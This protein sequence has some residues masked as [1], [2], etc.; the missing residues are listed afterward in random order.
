MAGRIVICPKCN[1]TIEDKLRI[2]KLKLL[3][4]EGRDEEEFFGVLLEKLGIRDVQ[5]AGVG[6]KTKIRPNLKT[7]KITDPFFDRVTSLGIIRDADENCNDAFKSVQDA[8][9]AA[10]LPCPKKPLVPTKALPKVTVLILPPGAARGALEDICLASAKEDLTMAC[11][12]DYFN[13][14]DAKGI[15]RP[16]KDF[17]KAKARVFLSSRADPILDVGIAAKKGYWSFDAPEFE[18]VKGFLRSL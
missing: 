18:K 8:L 5:I 13:C 17:V 3:I 9:K 6:G 16:V 11:V 7:L 1:E 14:L 15:G 2:E 4:V 10:G 12:D